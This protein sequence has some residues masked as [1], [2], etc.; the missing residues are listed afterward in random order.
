MSEIQTVAEKLNK[1]CRII[2]PMLEELRE[3][4]FTLQPWLG[5]WSKKQILGHL[6]DSAANNHQRFVRIQY[7]N[8][9]VIFYEQ[10]QWVHLQ[11]YNAADTKDLIQLWKVY[12]LHLV[13]VIK[14]ISSEHLD[15]KGIT[16]S[17]QKYSLAWYINDYVNHLEHHLKQIFGEQSFFANPSA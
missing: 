10:D 11:Q 16:R 2:P 14:N 5:K 1:L 9:P 3:E 7:E 6:I 8:E 15:K 12:N 17:G 4:D 13:H